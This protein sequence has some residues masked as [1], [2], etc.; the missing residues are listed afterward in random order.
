MILISG[1]VFD[2]LTPPAEAERIVYDFFCRMNRIE[3]PVVVIAG[4]HDSAQRFDSR[5]ALFS[6]AGVHVAGR[7]SKDAIFRPRV[8]SGA[9]VIVGALPFVSEKSVIK[10]VDYLE[11]PERELRGN[12]SDR[13][14]SMIQSLSKSFHPKAINLLMTHLYFEGAVR[15]TSEREMDLSSAYLVPSNAIPE[16]VN[17]FAVGHIHK[18][19]KIKKRTIPAYYSGSI[20]KLDF[21]EEKDE[22]G[23]LVVDANPGIPA[24]VEFIPLTSVRK[25]MNFELE[26]SMLPKL[27]DEINAKIG[28]RGYGKIKVHHDQPVLNLAELIKQ[29]VPRAIDWAIIRPVQE[30]AAKRIFDQAALSNPVEMYRSYHREEYGKDPG[31][32]LIA[33]LKSLYEQATH[34]SD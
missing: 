12:Y 14:Q 7:A 27:A 5:A 8:K 29:F 33:A 9:E 18:Q 23:F 19:Q 21:G 30:T 15:S 17:Y 1:D 24:E 32:D 4:N 10:G 31:D 11:K 22:K 13:I 20:M 3:V 16:N 6:I 26:L 25:L 2:V 28:E 34:A